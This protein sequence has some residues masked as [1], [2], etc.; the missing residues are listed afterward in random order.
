MSQ[1]L[2]GQ[3]LALF[4]GIP[5]STNLSY[6][7]WPPVDEQTA[8]A[9]LEVYQSG[10]WSFKGPKENTFAS[11]FAAY[12]DATYG[13]F[14]MNGTVALQCALEAC[15]IQAGDEVIVPALTW[16]A[17]AS[18][19]SYIG[20]IP[21]FVDIDV[22]TFCLDP[23]RVEA[24]ITEKT[25]AIIPVHLY[26]ATADMEAIM[27]IAQRYNL[28][29]IED[30]AHAHGGKWDGRGLGS[31]GDAGAFSF[32]QSK[33]MSCG[34]GGICITNDENIAERLYRCKHIGYSQFDLPHVFANR[35]PEDLVCHNFRATEFQAVL[36]LNQ[37]PYLGQRIKKYN[38]NAERLTQMLTPLPGIRVQKCGRLANPQSYYGFILIFDEEP[39]VRVP[40]ETLLKALAAE[41]LREGVYTTYGPVYQHTLFNIPP[42]KY[43]LALEGCPVAEGLAFQRTLVLPHQW[44]GA[45]ERTIDTLGNIFLK[46][47]H[48]ASQFAA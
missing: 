4:G 11:D 19:V 43:R 35:P 42:S 40:L 41:G 47:S 5:T 23:Q 34:E 14:V 2:E 38:T 36:L 21:V 17:T 22:Q 9:L 37:L 31:W 16:L 46:I 3:K 30:C 29:V 25:R 44:L 24:A 32:Q 28:K 45:D 20:A 33:V 1:A 26:G 27:K 15:G 48:Q 10:C 18:A 12:H 8:H 39:L 7:S 6:P 13:V